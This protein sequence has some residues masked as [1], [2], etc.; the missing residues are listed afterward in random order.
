MK[1]AL[2]VTHR[3]VEDFGFDTQESWSESIDSTVRASRLSGGII[4]GISLLVGGIGIA[5]IMLASITERIR[6][7]GI[8]MAIGAKRLD[9]FLQIIIESSSLGFLG[10]II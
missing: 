2:L 1:S 5:N 9:I 10:G 3:G 7:I 6:E 8:R 4:A